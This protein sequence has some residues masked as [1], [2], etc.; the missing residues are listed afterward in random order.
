MKSTRLKKNERLIANWSDERDLILLEGCDNELVW[1]SQ[2]IIQSTVWMLSYAFSSRTLHH[3]HS[4]VSILFIYLVFVTPTLEAT[5][6]NDNWQ[7][8]VV[9]DE[10]VSIISPLFLIQSARK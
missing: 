6:L 9:N 7:F 3:F 2:F 4:S 10:S 5:E 8:P 1:T